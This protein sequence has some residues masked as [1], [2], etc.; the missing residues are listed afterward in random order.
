[1]KV[2]A[3]EACARASVTLLESAPAAEHPALVEHLRMRGD[4]TAGFLVRAVAAGKIDFFGAVLVSLTGQSAERIRAL[5]ATGRDGALT[6]LFRSARLP[7]AIDAAMLSALRVWREVANGR[8]IAGVQEVSWLMLKAL[9]A[10]PGHAEDAAAREV[11]K[12]IRSIHLDELRAN[13]RGHA[14]LIAAA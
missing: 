8:R 2:V 1:M 11:A 5:L 7:V 10:T 12:L 6:A 13:A 3:R 9:E 4:L 14:M